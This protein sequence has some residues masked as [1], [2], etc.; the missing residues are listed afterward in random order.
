MRI[1]KGLENIHAVIDKHQAE[2]RREQ[3]EEPEVSDVI[4]VEES[5]RR[6]LTANLDNGSGKFSADRFLG[7]TRKKSHAHAEQS[8]DENIKVVNLNEGANHSKLYDEVFRAIK[9]A[10]GPDEKIKV[11]AIFIPV[12]KDSSELESLPVDE[13]IT[14]SPVVEE[15]PEPEPTNEKNE[16]IVEEITEP[17]PLIEAA[18]E[19]T[20]PDITTVHE[21]LSDEPEAV[22]EDI[23]TDGN[24]ESIS[25]HTEA[26]QEDDTAEGIEE[27][28]QDIT[29][30][31]ITEEIVEDFIE[32]DSSGDNIDD[33]DGTVDKFTEPEASNEAPEEFTE[34]DTSTEMA[35]EVPQPLSIEE[36][37]DRIDDAQ[38]L[39][40]AN[41]LENLLPAG[42]EEP[43]SELAEAF[44]T[45]EEA[46]QTSEA[47]EILANEDKPDD[48][49]LT[50]PE[51]LKMPESVEELSEI[52]AGEP[53][54]FEEIPLPEELSDEEIFDDDD[55]DI[56]ILPDIQEDD[57]QG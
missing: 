37:L 49:E 17:E 21:D 42:P 19:F 28:V 6:R 39:E 24:I 12:V 53:L 38:A 44:K 13:E 54:E 7:T 5:V 11:V 22:M 46:M 1:F 29:E 48:T 2:W 57:K 23:V 47:P 43:D 10:S 14:L 41:S 33:V 35:D 32:P 16:S 50:E 20:E 51:A 26:P 31:D 34:P 3:G 45:M 9:D 15:I 4:S 27:V 36:Q 25:E 30:P 55:S 52:S 56:E 8:S 18:V 40:E